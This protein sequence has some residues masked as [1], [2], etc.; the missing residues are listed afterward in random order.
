MTDEPVSADELRSRTLAGLRW[1]VIGRP[2]V[3]LI[4]LG[5]MVVLARLVSP[6]EFGRYAVAILVSGLG[7]I[8][9]SGLTAALVQRPV[10]T[11]R[12]QQDAL[13]LSLIG[14][15]IA[16]ALTFVVADVLIT[17]IFGARTSV[18]I[19]WTAPGALIVA[20]N[21]VPS[22][23]LQREIALR[24]LS[25]LD[26]GG[27][28]A[29]AAVSIA[30]AVA[31]M[32]GLALVF[33]ALAGSLFAT[34]V[35]WI[36]APQP[37]PRLHR[38][39]SRELWRYAGPQSAATV[40]W[41]GF[42]NVDYAIVGA[43][44]GALQSGYYFRAYTLGVEYQKKVSQ[45]M[46]TVGFPV[47]SRT[48]SPEHMITVRS[49]MVRLLTLLLFPLL[50]MLSIVAPVLIPWV[51]GS[52]WSP[53]VVPTQILAA[54][55][56]ATLVID[57]AG[58]ALMAAG[59]PRALLGY[60]WAHFAAYGAA[61]FL[62]TPYG[63]AA[64][65]TAAVVVHTLFLLIAYVVMLEGSGERVLPRLWHDVGPAT[66]SSTLMAAFAVPLSLGLK[67]VGTPPFFYL[68][69]IGLASTVVYLLV[70]RIRYHDAWRTVATFVGHLLPER[71]LGPLRGRLRAARS[72][73]AA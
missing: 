37:F 27:A 55:G 40:S 69:A 34:I 48:T 47:L 9:S 33:G 43:R 46:T 16:F 6:A 71:R 52:Q 45:V 39:E 44:L 7:L 17:P 67:A 4:L 28:I 3:E 60:G 49:Q 68:A 15:L 61:V 54:G 65:A 26:V 73:T 5:S 29:R 21:T 59:R 51:F 35:N 62:T 22:A 31:G 64:V 11:R 12:H 36:W 72:T 25:I 10:I 14:G 8:P 13:A 19:R 23:L 56:A 38:A 32:Q 70:V 63:L 1:T 41:I 50:A 20:F 57:A 24:R 30:L 53:A 66:V 2:S 42:Q 18:L 58:A